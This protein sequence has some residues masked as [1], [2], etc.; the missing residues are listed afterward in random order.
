MTIQD[1]TQQDREWYTGSMKSMSLEEPGR[2]QQEAG[3]GLRLKDQK[4][5]LPGIQE[6]G[7]VFQTE[8]REISK[9]DF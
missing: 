8:P 1:V 6:Q 9:L 7:E 5:D 3:L 4:R 2:L